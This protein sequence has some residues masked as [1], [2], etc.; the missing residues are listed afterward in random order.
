MSTHSDPRHLDWWKAKLAG[1]GDRTLSLPKYGP[2]ILDVLI[3]SRN[4]GST[5][6]ASRN[7]D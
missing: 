5:P 4:I 2:I 3:A 6:Q 1:M 7:W